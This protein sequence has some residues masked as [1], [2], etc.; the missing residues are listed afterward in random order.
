MSI[1]TVTCPACDG[2][3]EVEVE[4]DSDDYRPLLTGD[5]LNPEDRS[6]YSCSCMLTKE[7]NEIAWM[8]AATIANTPRDD[9]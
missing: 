1:I 4:H 8:R 6:K 3:I 5:V 7:Q 2:D 9:F